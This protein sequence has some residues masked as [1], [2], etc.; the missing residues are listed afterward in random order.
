MAFAVASLYAAL[1]VETLTVARVC[2]RVLMPEQ[3]VKHGV[4][5]SG[6]WTRAAVRHRMTIENPTV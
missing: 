1:L 4:T 5:Y 2:V 3:P 6:A